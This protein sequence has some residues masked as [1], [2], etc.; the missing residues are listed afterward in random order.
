MVALGTQRRSGRADRGAVVKRIARFLH[1]VAFRLDPQP[2]VINASGS[3]ADI[4]ALP[5]G[6]AEEDRWR[7]DDADWDHLPTI[8]EVTDDG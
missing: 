3:I 5:R 7:F 4:P 2:L 1:A 6:V 8:D